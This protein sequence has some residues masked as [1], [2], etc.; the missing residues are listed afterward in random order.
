MLLRDHFKRSLLYL[1]CFYC[2]LLL[3][4]LLL[5]LKLF[6]QLTHSFSLILSVVEWIFF[7]VQSMLEMSHSFQIVQF[8]VDF[9]FNCRLK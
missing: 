6:T 1:I 4:L 9:F 5:S 7:C 8:G 2:I 3:I